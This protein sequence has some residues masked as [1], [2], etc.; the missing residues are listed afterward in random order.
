MIAMTIPASTNRTI[1]ACIQIHSGG[2]ATAY[3]VAGACFA[4]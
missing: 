3:A 4:P 1:S 2:T